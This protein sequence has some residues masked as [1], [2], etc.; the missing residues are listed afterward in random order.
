ME[1]IKS[2]EAS[3]IKITHGASYQIDSHKPIID[4]G[5]HGQFIGKNSRNSHSWRKLIHFEFSLLVHHGKDSFTAKVA[6]TN[7]SHSSKAANFVN[8]NKIMLDI[9]KKDFK[10]PLKFG[11]PEKKGESNS[12]VIDYRLLQ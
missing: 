3:I 5:D 11:F 9:F 10:D 1:L 7:S 6:F 12:A 2:G 4:K 8:Y